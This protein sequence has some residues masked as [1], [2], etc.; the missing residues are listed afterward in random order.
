M[1]KLLITATVK[2]T[3]VQYN[4]LQSLILPLLFELCD[5]VC[6]ELFS[7]RNFRLE[8]FV[9]DAAARPLVPAALNVRHC[10][11]TAEFLFNLGLLLFLELVHHGV[12][13]LCHKQLRE[14]VMLN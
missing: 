11:F 8:T 7:A 5:L 14:L 13:I 6:L 4:A 3:L 1:S 12:G 10:H 2:V 9:D